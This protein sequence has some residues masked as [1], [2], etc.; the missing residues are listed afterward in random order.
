MSSRLVARLAATAAVALPAPSS[1]ARA[2]WC[3][4][5]VNFSRNRHGAARRAPAGH[6]Q[7]SSRVRAPFM[8]PPFSAAA[9]A[10]PRAGAETLAGVP[11]P[12]GDATTTLLVI[13]SPEHRGGAQLRRLADPAVVAAWAGGRRVD[14]HVGCSVDD[15]EDAILNDADSNDPV[16]LLWWFGDAKTMGEVL[17]RPAGKRVA[18][19]HSGAAGV[20]HLLREPA[21]KRLSDVPLTNARGAFSASLGEWAVFSFLWFNKNVSRMRAAQ[22]NGEWMRAPVGMLSGKSV[23]IIGYGDIG[24][25]VATR[26]RAMGMRVVGLRRDPSKSEAD[27]RGKVLD[28]I[29]ALSGDELRR[30]VA[31]ADF[32]VLALPHTAETEGL[33]SREIIFESMKPSSIL[34]NLGRG[35]V[36]DEEA[37]IEAL[38]EGKIAGA[39]LDVTTQEPLPK[40]HPLYALENV[41]L[42]F[43]TADLTDDYFDL[44]LQVFAQHLR[45]YAGEPVADSRETGLDAL[46]APA[47]NLVDKEKGY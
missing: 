28:A 26:S 17:R 8:P 2:S 42:S 34:V 1:R 47:W 21:I 23:A 44:T 6:A 19:M 36:V 10:S 29:E 32:V 4:S 14:V 43:H 31:E 11:V 30:V 3:A 41:L 46:H 35:A 9:M 38:R 40:G 18:W 15:F 33:F 27:V 13:T 7:D 16:V 39:A 25:A 22:A 24:R 45:A 37:L 5:L 12:A 20:E